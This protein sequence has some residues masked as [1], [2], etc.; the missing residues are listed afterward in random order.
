MIRKTLDTASTQTLTALVCLVILVALPAVSTDWL[1]ADLSIYFSYALFAASLAFVWGHCGLLCLGQAVFFGLGAYAMSFVTLGM[2]PGAAGLVSTWAGF[3][4][5]MIVPALFAY[6]LGLFLFSAKGLE[7]PFF[8]IVTLAV[9]FVVERL[10]INWDYAGGLNGLMNVPPINLGLNGGGFEVW[11]TG[12][13]Y[14]AALVTLVIGFLALTVILQSRW[15]LAAKALSLHETRTRA[16]G[17]D[18]T[19]YKATAFAIGAAFSGL[20]GALFVAQF[21]FA[22]PSLIGFTLS[23]EV[24]IWVALGGRGMLIAACLGAILVRVLESNLS[25]VF[26]ETWLLLLGGLFIACVMFLP[27]GLIG[28]VIHRIDSLRSRDSS[29]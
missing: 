7:G 24:L 12:P 27:R 4:A 10:F 6:V 22:S 3:A 14:Y 5:A 8:G 28:D 17:Y 13:L 9:A 2:V 19:A 18:T 21:G 23:A 29:A 1:L 26:N 25:S 20:A 11:E 16:L 15:G